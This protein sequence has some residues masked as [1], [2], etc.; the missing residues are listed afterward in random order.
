MF[1]IVDSESLQVYA[2]ADTERTAKRMLTNTR[3]GWKLRGRKVRSDIADRL[4]VMSADEFNELNTEVEVRNL[5]SG[6]IVKILKSELGSCTDPSTE[7]YW[8]M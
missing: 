7:R 4:V 3:R 6:N 5:M 8:S 2:S 1:M